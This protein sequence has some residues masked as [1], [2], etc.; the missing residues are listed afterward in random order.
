MR[1]WNRA[2][3]VYSSIYIYIVLCILFSEVL[4]IKFLAAGEHLFAASKKARCLCF[5]E[6][7]AVL[8]L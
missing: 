3:N 4:G 6:T 8:S 2:F 5:L 7:F 1:N